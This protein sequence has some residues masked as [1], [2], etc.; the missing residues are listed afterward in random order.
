[1]SPVFQNVPDKV[2]EINSWICRPVRFASKQ[3][4][5]P[6]LVSFHNSFCVDISLPNSPPTLFLSHVGH[7]S[8]LRDSIVD[9]G[10]RRIQRTQKNAEPLSSSADS[11]GCCLR[12]SL[13]VCMGDLNCERCGDDESLV[14]P[15]CKK[16]PFLTPLFTYLKC[17]FKRKQVDRTHKKGLIILIVLKKY[18]LAFSRTVGH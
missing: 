10:K 17:Y 4:L 15:H 12:A 9:V 5:R 16:W 2:I 1:M 7:F 18:F 3:T 6:E 8:L 11:P 14:D 13:V